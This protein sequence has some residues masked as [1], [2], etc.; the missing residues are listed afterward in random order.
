[1]KLTFLGTSTSVGIPVIGCSCDICMSGNPKLHRL[2]SSIHI[3][4][5]DYSILVDS[6]PDLRAQSLR[7]SLSKVDAVL[8]THQHLD[9]TA[10]FDEL[11]AFCWKREDP[12]PLYSTEACLNELKRIYD[13]AFSEGNSYK[14]YIKPLAIPILNHVEFGNLKVT[15][16]PVEHGSV[17]TVGYRFDSPNFS[18]AY[19]PDVKRLKPGSAEML[20]DLDCFIVDCLREEEHGTH[21][22]LH[23]SLELIKELK[24]KKAWLTHLSHELDVLKVEPLLPNHIDF[25][26]DTLS[27]VF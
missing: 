3:E 20:K 19:L 4:Y 25:A 17:V 10:G 16:I 2:R 12:L 5:D 11:R 27:L 18:I 21:L 23:E 1:M 13:W 22:S 14:G 7:H 26:Y 8:Y 6:G 9:H 24:P 15:P